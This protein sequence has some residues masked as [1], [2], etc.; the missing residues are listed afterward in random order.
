VGRWDC[1]ASDLV[2]RRSRLR[3]SWKVMAS[4]GLLTCTSV[5]RRHNKLFQL[6][7]TIQRIVTSSYPCHPE[8]HVAFSLN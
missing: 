1:K 2:G 6:V 3:G 8:R 5:A 4:V 7:F